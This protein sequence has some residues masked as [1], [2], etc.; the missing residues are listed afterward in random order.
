MHTKIRIK[1]MCEHLLTSELITECYK[2]INKEEGKLTWKKLAQKFS[3]QDGEDLRQK[4]K[5]HRKKNGDLPSIDE[6]ILKKH[7]YVDSNKGKDYKESVQINKDKTQLS[8]R[9]IGVE[10][11]KLKDEDY[12]LEL[13]GYDKS[14]WEVT[15]LKNSLWDSRL[16]GGE[17]MKMYSSKLS[18][19]PR[20][21]NIWSKEDA[22]K[23]FEFL[24]E[25]PK[26]EIKISKIKND[27]SKRMLIV[28]IADFHYNLKSSMLT[29][30]N[31]YNCEIAEENFYYVISQVLER[32]KGEKFEKV[33]LT[34]G[35]DFIN[36]DN[37]QGTT[38]A[39]T[40][41]DNDVT[42]QEAVKGATKLIRDAIENLREIAP[43]DVLNIPSNHDMHT[44][45]GIAELLNARYEDCDD[46]NIINNPL[47]NQYYKYG[48]NLT[49]LAHDMP[50][51]RALSIISHEAKKDW[52][53]C[54]HIMCMLAHLHT[55]MQYEKQ[56]ELEIMRLPTFS[57]WSRWT[58]T[59][60]YVSS[61]KRCDI[62]IVDKDKGIVDKKVIPIIIKK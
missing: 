48:N 21:T 58:K 38:T 49:C 47:P 31:E 11:E 45:F 5:S 22:K 37:M 59:K 35:N 53:H 32:V 14:K 18:I 60:G 50:I 16:K 10:D 6:M 23:V 43:V 36:A 62:Y 56:G 55:G 13:H 30:G 8:D 3:L 44:M 15:S 26:K 25:V 29:S 52:S 17:V 34:I 24:Y 57:G 9:L 42:W 4:F 19:K 7:G 33:L 51:K 40:P 39:G 27:D 61:E 12:I 1:G 2:I 46:I 28:P 41:Q 20:V 54:D